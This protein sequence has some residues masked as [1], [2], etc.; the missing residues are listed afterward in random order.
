MKYVIELHIAHIYMTRFVVVVVQEAQLGE[1]GVKLD[2]NSGIEKVLETKNN[3][4]KSLRY[5]LG[6]M[7][8]VISNCQFI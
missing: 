7:T 6:K 2:P 8:K 5:D 3:L 1:A 4:I